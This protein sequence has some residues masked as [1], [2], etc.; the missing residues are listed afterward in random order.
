MARMILIRG[1]PGT[2]KT[3]EAM[4]WL[5]K[6]YNHFEADQFFEKDGEY[7]FDRS[8]LGLAHQK[9]YENS[10]FSIIFGEDVVISNTFTQRWE[11]E[12]Y[13]SL[14]LR[15][16]SLWIIEMRTEYGSIHGVPP[17][18]VDKMRARF[19][20]MEKLEDIPFQ[21]Y[22]MIRDGKETVVHEDPTG[23]IQ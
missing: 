8:V 10:K 13:S 1:L 18:T 2:G 17:E 22:S 11:I 16:D 23:T 3:T 12:I 7:K 4:K 15:G 21:R 14:L 20:H 19:D 5:A 6:G 9:C